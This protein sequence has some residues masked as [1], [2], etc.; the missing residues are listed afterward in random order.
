WRA[1]A[2]GHSRKGCPAVVLG[3]HRLEAERLSIEPPEPVGIGGRQADTADPIQGHWAPRRFRKTAYSVCAP[4]MNSLF[5]IGPPNARLETR[6]GSSTFPSRCPR[7]SMQ[8]TPS[9][10]LLQRLPSSSTRSPS[11]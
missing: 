11:Q 5:F 4:R 10:A 9:P 3:F 7:G 8:C 2:A 6:Y 1:L